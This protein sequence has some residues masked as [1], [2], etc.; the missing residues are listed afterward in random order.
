M[1]PLAP[2]AADTQHHRT[3]NFL[4]SVPSTYAPAAARS[5]AHPGFFFEVIHGEER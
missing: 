4:F 1:N 5:N 3:A 2:T